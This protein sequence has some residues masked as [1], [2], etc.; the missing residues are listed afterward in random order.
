MK[1]I[2]HHKIFYKTFGSR[3]FLLSDPRCPSKWC[4][5][6]I[7]AS[8]EGSQRVSPAIEKSEQNV[9]ET[10][11]AINGSDLSKILNRSTTR[12]GITFSRQKEVL[13]E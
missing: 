10:E 1:M 11:A 2:T 4:T 13:L 3:Q 12:I 7:Q 6:T 5:G 9:T 8:G